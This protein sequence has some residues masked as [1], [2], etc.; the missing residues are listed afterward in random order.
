MHALVS[1]KARM[2]ARTLLARAGGV[3]MWPGIALTERRGAARIPVAADVTRF[4]IS[5]DWPFTSASA[6][7]SLNAAS[8]TGVPFACIIAAIAASAYRVAARAK[9]GVVVKHG[10]NCDAQWALAPC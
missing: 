3:F 1:G 8:P 9:C 6:T 5:A 2:A 4:W 7:I 10:T